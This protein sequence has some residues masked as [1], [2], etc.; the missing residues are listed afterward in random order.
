MKTLKRII[1]VFL[2]AA[3]GSAIGYLVYTGNRLASFP[4][5]ETYTNKVFISS[6]G[7]I[8]MEFKN[9]SDAIYTK[10]RISISISLT[11]YEDGILFFYGAE[12]E[13]RFI[14]VSKTQI[15]DTGSRKVLYGK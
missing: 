2:L 9:V 5:S 6:D 1:C 13:Y 7:E 8:E 3:I 10:D 15:F 4:A 14:A 11:S 12:R